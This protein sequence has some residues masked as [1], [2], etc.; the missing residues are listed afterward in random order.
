[1]LDKRLVSMAAQTGKWVLGELKQLF[2]PLRL[3]GID[4]YHSYRLAP[5]KLW[6]A[7]SFSVVIGI[8]ILREQ[9][10]NNTAMHTVGDIL[11][12]VY[13]FSV[14]Y[15]VREL[16]CI[17]SICVHYTN[18]YESKGMLLKRQCS[19]RDLRL[20]CLVYSGLSTALVSV[21]MAALITSKHH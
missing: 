9:Q 4:T 6:G 7:S 13:V 17:L 21:L 8:Q 10:Y 16:A 20:P 11:S 1:M 3:Q 19:Q 14:C 18:S 5:W 15:I 12:K 2:A